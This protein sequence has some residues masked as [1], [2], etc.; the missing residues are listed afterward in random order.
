M[1]RTDMLVMTAIGSPVGELRLVA[2]PAGLRAVL[3]ENDHDRIKVVGAQMITVGEDRVLQ[4]AADQ[5]AGYF[6]GTLREFDLPLDLDGTAF[7]VSAW[8]ALATIAY[9]STASYSAQAARIGRPR[10]VRAIGAANG[11]N[12]VSIILPCH[13]VIGADGSLT[14]FAGGLAAKRFLLDH[15]RT[16]AGLTLFP[17]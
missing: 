14:G 6:A 1:P 13:R 11:R 3:W 15:E 8:R 17:V 12:P 5:L 2:S 16:H 7:Q 4:S 10:A 9:G